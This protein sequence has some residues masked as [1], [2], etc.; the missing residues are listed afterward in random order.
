MAY[1][2]RE[3]LRRLWDKSVEDDVFFMA[4]S[5]AFNVML[6]LLPLLILGIGVTGYVLSARFG[7]P[8]EAVLGLL[9]GGL[10]ES[11][12][13]LGLAELLRGPVSQLVEGRYGF[14]LLGSLFFVWVA[15]RLVS[16]LRV[17]LR[18]VFD[19]GQSR[20]LLLG[21][22]FD[23]GMV[24]VGVLLLTLNL[25]VTIMIE[26]AMDLGVEMVS[27]QGPALGF[28]ERLLG[29]TVALVSI[30]ALF[31]LM[32]RYLPARR[33]PWRTAWIAAAF[34]ALCH[35]VLKTGFSWYATEVANYGTAF[36]NVATLAVLIFWIYYGSV[37]FILGGEVAQVY[38][39]RKASR[40]QVRESFEVE[41]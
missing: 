2:V 34:A 27:L 24:V 31:L 36:G 23:V 33:I 17:A 25:G 10:P 40:V 9:A 38:T 39:M 1:R 13:E 20:G 32:Y 16:T 21:K 37:V 35:E 28:A 30:A 4:G 11:G 18:E 12:T 22:L 41:A 15:T 14:T 29:H 5:I 3:F 7:D 6:A 8:T 26:G 19:V